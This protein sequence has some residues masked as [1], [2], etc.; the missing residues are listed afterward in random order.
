VVAL[1]Y[2]YWRKRFA[3]DPAVIGRK[4]EVDGIPHTI[5]G[6][7]PKEF[8]FVLRKTPV[9]LPLSTDFE[10]RSILVLKLNSGQT[11]ALPNTT[12]ATRGPLIQ[13]VGRLKPRC[14][15]WRLGLS[16]A[17]SRARPDRFPCVTI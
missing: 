12:V 10:V 16:C 7:L 11:V 15:R 9:W 5:V 3:A 14:Q 13:V 4:L 2:E 6:V 1:S 17:G 8:W